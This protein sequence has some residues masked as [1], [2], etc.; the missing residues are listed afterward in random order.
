MQNFIKLS[1]AV[2]DYGVKERNREKISDDA[3][4]LHSL[5]RAAK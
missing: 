2:Y 3:T 1:A 5:P 4:V